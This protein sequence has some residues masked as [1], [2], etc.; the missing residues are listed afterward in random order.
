[1][2]VLNLYGGPGTGKSTSAAMIFAMLKQSGVN[3]ELVTEFAKDLTWHRRQKT[4]DDQV[5][6]FGKQQHK[7][8][9]L[10]NQVDVV[11]TDSPLLLTLHYGQDT[12]ESLRDLAVEVYDSHDNIDV[13]LNRT[14]KYNP[15]GR[16]QTEEEARI[17]DVSIQN[18]LDV[19]ARGYS[20][21]E[22]TQT[23]Y[24]LIVQSVKYALKRKQNTDAR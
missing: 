13:F 20:V 12:Y 19:S 2:I 4:L 17:V 11:V 9:M 1:M 21:H 15:I 5:Y 3:A 22:T 7:L 24:D 8:H 18:I 6:V 16:T 14:K 10:R 23:S